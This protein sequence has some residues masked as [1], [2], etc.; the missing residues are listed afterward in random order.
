MNFDEIDLKIMSLLQNNAHLTI[1]EISQ[2]INL[3]ITPIHDR[4]KKLEKDGVIEKYVAIL[5]RKAIGKG[6]VAYCNVT[7]D[8][9]RQESFT[10]FN[11]AVLQMPEVVVCDVVSGTFDY[12]LKIVVK[13][14]E[15]YHQFYQE[16]LSALQS[17]SHINSFFVMSEVKN[18]T[19]LP[20]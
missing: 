16:K 19:A 8:K 18:T 4:I 3:S 10:E 1:K 20:L 14:V 7:L 17:I 13:D 12:L 9:Q 5:N 2:Q 6:L 15:S 11:S